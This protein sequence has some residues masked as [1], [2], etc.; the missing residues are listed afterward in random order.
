VAAALGT[1]AACHRDAP[2]VP[3]GPGFVP[4]LATVTL[5]PGATQS[6]RLTWAA[7]VPAPTSVRWRWRVSD[8][9]VAAIDSASADGLTVYLRGVA[10]G[11]TA[12]LAEESTLQAQ[13]SIAVT[14]R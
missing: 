7:N 1:I 13:V 10:P 12:V 8:P 6:V 9:A 11:S 14:V 5:V 2:F 3:F 4:S